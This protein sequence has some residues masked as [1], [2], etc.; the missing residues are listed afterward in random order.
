M[1][2][3]EDW[4][5]S[6]HGKLRAAMGDATLMLLLGR[7]VIR[8]EQ[9]RFLLIKRK[10]N[11]YWAFPAGSMEIGES[12]SQCAVRETREETGLIAEKATLIA[13]MTG[14]ENTFTDV[15]GCT[16]QHISGTYLLEGISG[17]LTPDPEEATAAEWFSA[18]SLPEPLSRSVRL[19][20]EHLAFYEKTG[21]PV[22]E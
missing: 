14:P 1:G 4:Q 3:V 18:S 15:F 17:T 2:S 20:I 6:Y 5:N 11:G 19:S 16:Y 8:D 7:G 13:L 12:L 9:G 21:C 22:V 10:D